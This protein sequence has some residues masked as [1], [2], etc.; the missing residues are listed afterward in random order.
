[1][2]LFI[3][4]FLVFL[5][6]LAHELGHAFAM[7]SRGLLIRRIGIGI[8]I[9]GIPTYTLKKVFPGAVISIS[10]LLVVAFVKPRKEAEII[11]DILPHRYSALINGAGILAN[12]FFA[13][14]I[15]SIWAMSAIKADTNLGTIFLF[16]F[17][18]VLISAGLWIWRD[19]F[20]RYLLPIF[21]PILMIAVCLILLTGRGEIIGPIGITQEATKLKGIWEYIAYAG[22]VSLGF[23]MINCLP[24]F[25]MDGGRI[26]GAILR[27]NGFLKL[28]SFFKHWSTL[29]FLIF[30]GIVIVKDFLRLF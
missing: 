12:I 13:L 9:P 7:R 19:Y 25:P 27:D 6:L 15:F 22:D 20:C 24:I 21:G 3:F 8:P 2:H 4:L 23:A 30:F 17:V 14:L 26:L 28:D 16:Y 29:V 11:L 18:V 1:M 5:T 10:P